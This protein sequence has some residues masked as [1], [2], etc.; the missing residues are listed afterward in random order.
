M[1]T[2]LA[3]VLGIRDRSEKGGN[4]LIQGLADAG[5]EIVSTGGSAKAIEAAGVPV[6]TVD[7][8]TGFPEMLDGTYPARDAMLTMHGHPQRRLVLPITSA[9]LLLSSRLASA[10]P[11]E[12]LSNF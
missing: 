3:A 6:M 10:Q 12:L 5:Y 1:P 7:R 8:L 2:R 4:L 9:R 11:D